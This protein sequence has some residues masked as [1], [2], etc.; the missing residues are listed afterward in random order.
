MAEEVGT[1]STDISENVGSSKSKVKSRL[2]GNNAFRNSLAATLVR[3][4][5]A[6]LTRVCMVSGLNQGFK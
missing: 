6:T 4:G 3:Y 5:M 1:D 2:A